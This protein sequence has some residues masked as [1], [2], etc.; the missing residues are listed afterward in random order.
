MIL[1]SVYVSQYDILRNGY[2]T[3]L[4]TFFKIPYFVF[5]VLSKLWF[6]FVVVDEYDFNAIMWL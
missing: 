5:P 2:Q 1:R 6:F 4:P 3:W